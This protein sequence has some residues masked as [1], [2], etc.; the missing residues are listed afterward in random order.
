M[1]PRG[2]GG[3]QQVS[4]GRIYNWSRLQKHRAFKREP[5]SILGGELSRA[6]GAK[7]EGRKGK[8]KEKRDLT[9]APE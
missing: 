4:S 1:L 3:T 6:L 9:I 5:L 7:G 8:E 2:Q